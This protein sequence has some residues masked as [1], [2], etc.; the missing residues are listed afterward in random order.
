M[1][2]L[3]QGWVCFFPQDDWLFFTATARG[4]I[5]SSFPSRQIL[6]V[7]KDASRSAPQ[8]LFENSFWAQTNSSTILGGPHNRHGPERLLERRRQLHVDAERSHE[9]IALENAKHF[10]SSVFAMVMRGK[11]RRIFFF[12]FFFFNST[13]LIGFV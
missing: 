5:V 7:K 13:L 12:F 2:H 10:E 11:R 8:K 9:D 6:A 4:F 1:T 3:N